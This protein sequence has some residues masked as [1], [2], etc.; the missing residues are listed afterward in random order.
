[1]FIIKLFKFEGEYG[2]VSPVYT[3]MFPESKA[4]TIAHGVWFVRIPKDEI[5]KA[6]NEMILT[7]KN[8]AAFDVNT[9][10]FMYADKQVVPLNNP[11]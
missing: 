2:W 5:T 7:N 8:V 1:M 4:R 6:I 3:S 11:S 10:K 9:K